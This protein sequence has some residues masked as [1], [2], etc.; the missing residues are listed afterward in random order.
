MNLNSFLKAVKKN[1]NLNIT[2]YHSHEAEG[3]GGDWDNEVYSG[4]I[5][6][7]PK[8]FHTAGLTDIWCYI[9]SNMNPYF[10]VTIN[11]DNRTEDDSWTLGQFDN[12]MN[13]PWGADIMRYW[14]P[15]DYNDMDREE[16]G[17]FF[18]DLKEMSCDSL[19]IKVDEY[20]I[21]DLM[22]EYEVDDPSDLEDAIGEND[23]LTVM[24][25]SYEFMS[26]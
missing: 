17:Q 1:N 20:A 26:Y 19:I 5:K 25:F 13:Q 4:M 24:G 12:V 6:N 21:R 23:A 22:D 14:V 16:K 9:D 10:K 11:M 18:Q 15:S 7:V 8:E 2:L 3:N